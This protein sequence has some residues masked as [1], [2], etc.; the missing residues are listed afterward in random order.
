MP[1][2]PPAEH[3]EGGLL[4]VAFRQVILKQIITQASAAL[5]VVVLRLG[6]VVIKGRLQNTD[7]YV[8]HLGVRHSSL[9][10]RQ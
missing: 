6:C 5:R 4:Y 7:D 10:V 1:P 8:W 3:P 9:C 2:P